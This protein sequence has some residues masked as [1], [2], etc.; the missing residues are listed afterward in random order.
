MA[1]RCPVNGRT[2]AQILSDSDLENIQLDGLTADMDNNV[3]QESIT[4]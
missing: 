3:V 2:S 4:Y 1:K